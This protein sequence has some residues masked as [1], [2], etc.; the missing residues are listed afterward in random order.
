MTKRS[1]ILD[2][3][4]PVQ[5]TE[6][7]SGQFR[8]PEDAG[9]LILKEF[10]VARRH[11]GGPTLSTQPNATARSWR[12]SLRTP[13]FTASERR[14]SR[15]STTNS[16]RAMSSLGPANKAVEG[17]C[18]MQLALAYSEQGPTTTNPSR[19]QEV[20]DEGLCRSSL[21][22]RRTACGLTVLEYNPTTTPAVRSPNASTSFPSIRPSR[23]RARN[24]LPCTDGRLM[25]AIRNLRNRR[26]E[27][28][29]KKYPHGDIGWKSH[30][31]RVLKDEVPK[32]K[33]KGK[34]DD[35]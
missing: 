5:P 12:S 35:K 26:A 3:A 15:R 13:T 10:A 24:V 22:G 16:W 30:V 8:L 31:Q 32:L 28:F 18:L 25:R 7:M 21:R 9:C 2:A 19:L 33:D 20:S 6:G 17:Y 11:R 4:G 34:G 27:Q 1:R 23:R 29:I 14:T